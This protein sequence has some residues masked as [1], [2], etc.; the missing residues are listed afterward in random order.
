MD[1][2]AGLSP[3]NEDNAASICFSPEKPYFPLS[4]DGIIRRTDFFGDFE[5][6]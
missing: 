6:I 2:A 5:T 4:I 1:E 3:G